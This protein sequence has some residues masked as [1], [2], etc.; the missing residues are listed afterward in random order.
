MTA[1]CR[2]FQ[3]RPAARGAVR[4]TDIQWPA[5]DFRMARLVLSGRETCEYQGYRGRTAISEILPVDD[6]LDELIA[7]GA[8]RLMESA[9]L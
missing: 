2:N 7:Q 1:S 6:A 9:R 5:R 4:S 8:H 3:G